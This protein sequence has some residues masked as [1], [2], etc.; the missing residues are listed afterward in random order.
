MCLITIYQSPCRHNETREIR[1]CESPQC[2]ILN[3]EQHEVD[4]DDLECAVCEDEDWIEEDIVAKVGK[5]RLSDI[6]VLDE[7]D[8]T[9][10]MDGDS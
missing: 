4:D 5:R 6:I 3:W 2:E 7:E 1:L 10:V 8:E 9:M